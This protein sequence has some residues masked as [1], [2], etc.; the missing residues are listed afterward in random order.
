VSSSYSISLL[1]FCKHIFSQPF[2]LHAP[3][4]LIFLDLIELLYDEQS[5]F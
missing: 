1:Q 3:P 5:K 4:N 2:V